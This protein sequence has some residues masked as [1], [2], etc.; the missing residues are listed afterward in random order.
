LTVRESHNWRKTL[1][2]MDFTK[3]QDSKRLDF[4]PKKFSSEETTKL[5]FVKTLQTI[6][7]SNFNNF[8]RFSFHSRPE[9]SHNFA[10]DS[11][12]QYLR[13]V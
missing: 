13:E 7:E 8:R 9:H 1:E 10:S 12:H 4:P 6:T 11:A 3:Q 2:H 5:D